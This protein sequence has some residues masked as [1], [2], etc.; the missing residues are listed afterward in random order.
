MNHFITENSY[1]DYVA[2]EL[3][4]VNISRYIDGIEIENDNLLEDTAAIA[5][6][7]FAIAEIFVTVKDQ[8]DNKKQE[9]ND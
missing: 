8:H 2:A 1:R 9:S 6:A 4:L 7:S 5:K 3:F